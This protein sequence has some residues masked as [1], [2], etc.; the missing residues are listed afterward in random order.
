M[1]LVA[2]PGSAHD[3]GVLGVRLRIVDG[4]QATKVVVVLRGG[5]THADGLAATGAT[6]TVASRADPANA[7]TYD[8]P[9]AGW[10][11]DTPALARYANR[12]APAGGGVRSGT[13]RTGIVLRTVTRSLGDRSLLALAADPGPIDVIFSAGPHRLC[14]TFDDVVWS[15]PAGGGA[16]LAA[17]RSQTPG[18]CTST[19]TTTSTTSTLP[20][21]PSS[22]VAVTQPPASCADDAGC[23][24][25]YACAGGV[26]TGGACTSRTDC[27][28][29]GECVLPGP[30]PPGTCVCRGCGPF[31]CPLAC[32]EGLFLSGCVCAVES[33][34]PPEDDVCYLGFC[35]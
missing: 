26:C 3:A 7:A 27:P 17:G 33:D 35:S 2:V 5:G 34:C 20:G 23:P 30:D 15:A 16:R 10:V 4:P 21:Q 31:A 32:R 13:L 19:V 14:A 29:D 12:A 11:T 25:G 8:L 24:P 18:A 1:A 9:A 6:L 22:C 28:L